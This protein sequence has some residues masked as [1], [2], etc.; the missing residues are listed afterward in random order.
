M[1]VVAV[2]NPAAKAAEIKVVPAAIAVPAKIVHVHIAPYVAYEPFANIIAPVT[3]F[4][5]F[6]PIKRA[7]AV[8]EVIAAKYVKALAGVAAFVE[9]ETDTPLA[10]LHQIY[11]FAVAHYKSPLSVAAFPYYLL[12]KVVNY[13]KLNV[14]IDFAASPVKE[15]KF[16]TKYFATVAEEVADSWASTP[17][18]QE[19]QQID[20]AP[21][22]IWSVFSADEAQVASQ[23]EAGVTAVTVQA[24]KPY[25]AAS[26]AGAK[27]H[28]IKIVASC[29][30]PATA[31]V[32]EHVIAAA[33][34]PCF[35]LA[36]VKYVAAIPAI[37]AITPAPYK[38][39]V[40][41][42]VANQVSKIEVAS[43]AAYGQ[44]QAAAAPQVLSV[45]A[46]I[47]KSEAVK[48]EEAKSDVKYFDSVSA[49][50]AHSSGALPAAIHKVVKAVEHV[51]TFAFY[52]YLASDVP[53]AIVPG[54]LAVH[55]VV[56][57][58]YKIADII[59]KKEAEI[60]AFKGIPVPAILAVALPVPVN[61]K[62]VEQLLEKV[63]KATGGL[64]KATCVVDAAKV[65]TFDGVKI[66]AA[67][68]PV[69][70]EVL[71]AKFAGA[72]D[73]AAIFM[74]KKA[75][76]VVVK[77]VKAGQ[78]IQVQAS[79]AGVA[80]AI[81]GQAVAVA[82][83]VP[84]AVGGVVVAKIVPA[85]GGVEVV[86]PIYTVTKE[87][88]A[89]VISEVSKVVDIRQI[90][91]P[92]AVEIADKVIVTKDAVVVK[93]TPISRGKIAGACGNYNGE[94][95]DDKIPAQ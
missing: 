44:A 81:N 94:K 38:V 69:G 34:T 52:P 60:I 6:K 16:V 45:K 55:V 18:S 13:Q 59:V 31:L 64:I 26:I 49:E 91:K 72:A 85:A 8:K 95:V 92:A 27:V 5:S 76:A 80:V 57:P 77:V 29:V 28:N 68:I 58:K 47:H 90:V 40:E 33:V 93:V 78:V 9:H 48:A 56:N 22:G 36:H 63:D 54:K 79:A 62:G 14:A 70:K 84:V 7:A 23:V 53:A 15:F 32:Y 2:C 3:A 66:P 11:A 20:V 71:L 65:V 74:V 75:G 39:V 82:G 25:G 46:K 43:K 83:V 51:L 86:L 41:V 87:S 24:Q 61:M 4:P 21:A 37:A 19:A 17:V 12:E 10:S 30:G 1:T 73:S 89:A 42:S 67:A 88:V 50:V 35:K